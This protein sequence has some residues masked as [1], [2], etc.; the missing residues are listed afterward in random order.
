MIK[1]SL[2]AMLQMGQIVTKLSSLKRT[3]NSGTSVEWVRKQQM[4]VTAKADGSIKARQCL[5]A[6]RQVT[7]RFLGVTLAIPIGAKKPKM[8]NWANG[9]NA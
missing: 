3:T 5:V 2:G 7:N 1:R 9:T 8:V 4:D 6:Q